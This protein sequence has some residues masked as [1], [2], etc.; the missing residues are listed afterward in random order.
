MPLQNR[1]DPHSQ[2][3]A[4]SVRGLFMVTVFGFSQQG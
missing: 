1:V 3:H 2:L 4:V